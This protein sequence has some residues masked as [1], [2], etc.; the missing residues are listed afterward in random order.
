MTEP[1]VLRGRESSTVW[2]G[3]SGACT[4]SGAAGAKPKLR[5]EAPGEEWVLT[6]QGWPSVLQS[7]REVPAR[8]SF[9]KQA[10]P[11]S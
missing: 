11:S 1:T 2:L 9:I 5:R 4:W 3:L 6:G 7:G 10:F 8:S